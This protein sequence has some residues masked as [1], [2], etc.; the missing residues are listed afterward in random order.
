MKKITFDGRVA[1]V[2]GAGG[3]LGRAYA[4]ELARRGAAVVV[5]DLGGARDGA[6]QGSA[7]PADQVVADIE[8]AG[9]RAV[10]NYDSVATAEGGAAIVR[11]AL[12]NF[13][14]L[15]ILINNAGILRDKTFIKMASDNWRAVLNVH[16]DGAYHVS[17]PA[18]AAMRENNFGRILM[19]TSA[20][21]LYGNF[22][23]TN[24][25]AAKMAL[26]GVMNALKLEGQKY[27]ILVN[28]IAPLAA[29]RLTEDVMPAEL[30]ER[31]RPEY[32]TPM[33][34]Y[35]CSEACG[36]TGSVFNAG[37]GFFNRAAVMTGAP[38]QL[39]SGE[40]IPTVEEIAEHWERINDLSQAKE[41]FDLNAATL[42]LMT[43]PAAPVEKKADAGA[44]GAGDGGNIQKVFDRMAG[45]FRPEAAAGVDVVF[46]FMISGAGGG[47]WSCAI[48]DGACSIAHGVHPKPACTLAMA[49]PDFTAMMSG[50]LPPM[51]AFTSGKLKISGDIMKSQMIEKIFAIR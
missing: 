6:G 11:C 14:R 33:A 27:N 21:G 48:Q 26:V 34:L 31:A 49:A 15:D 20:A 12:E 36:L 13:G 46:Q 51:Q 19:T 37:L 5:N 4:L 9:G 22:G 38:V 1:I 17:R 28:T 35:L 18:F 39:G 10:A 50:Q 2:T 43:P 41:L 40:H 42:D 3:G 32:V 30:F 23:Q 45:A 44:T 7:S 24:Y 16:L 25:S 8:A 29:S 47:E